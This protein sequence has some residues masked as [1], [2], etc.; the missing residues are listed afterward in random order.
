MKYLDFKQ[1]IKKYSSHLG[2]FLTL[3]TGWKP[4][5]LCLCLNLSSCISTIAP[6]ILFNSTTEHVFMPGTVNQIGNGRIIKK[7]ESCS[8]NSILFAPFYN[9][10][11]ASL[12][13]AMKTSGIKQIGVVDYRSFN[14]LGPIY[15]VHCIIVWGEG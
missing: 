7:G 13:A 3:V 15:Y 4:V 9:G 6:G 12:E 1:F 5:V 14:I 10:K 11:L 8:Y 2:W